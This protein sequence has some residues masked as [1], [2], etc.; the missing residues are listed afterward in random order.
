MVGRSFSENDVSQLLNLIGIEEQSSLSQFKGKNSNLKI[1]VDEFRKFPEYQS[2]ALECSV[3]LL[4]YYEYVLKKLRNDKEKVEKF[5]NIMSA[6]N[7]ASCINVMPPDST[8]YKTNFIRVNNV[9]S[10]VLKAYIY[11]GW[12]LEIPTEENLEKYFDNNAVKFYSGEQENPMFIFYALMV[13]AKAKDSSRDFEIFDED[14]EIRSDKLF[15]AA[16]RGLDHQARLL[17]EEDRSHHSNP[18]KD[19]FK[20]EIEK[21]CKEHSK[22][23]NEALSS[24]KDTQ[25]KL[26]LRRPSYSALSELERSL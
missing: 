8:D 5:E 6:M 17:F 19:N 1:L 13:L 7:E 12:D 23:K 11:G 25:K 14:N 15:K 26:I 18:E 2:E 20:E 24:G 4:G 10:A 21:A 9:L 16:C 22:E 3:R